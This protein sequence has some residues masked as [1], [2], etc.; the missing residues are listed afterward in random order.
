MIR[1]PMSSLIQMD[2]HS[3]CRDEKASLENR[4]S[5]E[6]Y[7]NHKKESLQ[8][9]YRTNTWTRCIGNNASR[10]DHDNRHTVPWSNFH[11]PRDGH[12]HG[13]MSPTTVSLGISQVALSSPV[14]SRALSTRP[15][16]CNGS[17]ASLDLNPRRYLGSRG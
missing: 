2:V 7:H 6:V 15:R 4:L 5:P 8:Y 11:F 12:D 16:K 3:S 9:I 1:S 10:I 17:R 13:A 14:T